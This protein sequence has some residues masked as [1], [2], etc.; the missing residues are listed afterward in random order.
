MRAIKYNFSKIDAKKY[1]LVKEINRLIHASFEDIKNKKY[2]N[3]TVIPQKGKEI[4]ETLKA[5]A[6]K[7]KDEHIANLSFLFKVYFDSLISISK[8][9]ELCEK[10]EYQDAWHHLQG[11]LQ[12]IQIIKGFVDDES[13][14]SIDKIYAY[15]H[16]IEELYPYACFLSVEMICKKRTCS[17]CK[18]SVFDPDCDHIAGDL[19][20]GEMA[21]QVVGD[22]EFIGTSL[23]ENPIDKRC[24]I[25]MHEDKNKLE[26]GPFKAIH[27]LIKN[28]KIPLRN[29]EIS[30][31]KR[32][33]PRSFYEHWSKDS[34]CP[35]GSRKKFK[36]CCYKNEFIFNPHYQLL[37]KEPITLKF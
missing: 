30:I 32:K 35:C 36:D 12:N 7:N 3:T 9:W 31:T 20:W 28:S 13:Q 17:I 22:I 16:N 4:C 21:L 2:E 27:C 19:Y 23:V 25:L 29:F 11:A 6:R 37:I 18:K 34:F 8:F 1:P 24:V 33:L 14:L 26:E 15:L 10:S 5:E